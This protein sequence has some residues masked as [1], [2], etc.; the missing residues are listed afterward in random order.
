MTPAELKAALAGLPPGSRQDTTSIYAM[1]L[2]FWSDDPGTNA[3]VIEFISHTQGNRALPQELDKLRV[4]RP[5]KI[6]GSI[7]PFGPTLAHFAGHTSEVRGVAVL[8]WLGLDHQVIVTISKD[9]S[10]RVWD[11]RDPGKELAASMATLTIC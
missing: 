1:A 3:A 7:R 4:D 2:P 11:P 10:A 5:Y 8:D 9:G 6:I